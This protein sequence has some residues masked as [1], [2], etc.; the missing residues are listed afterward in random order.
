MTEEHKRKIGL[1]NKGKRLGYK[2]SEET[3]LKLSIA[4]KGITSWNKGIPMSDDLKEKISQST[5]KEKNHFWGKKH[6]QETKE[7]IS[8]SRKKLGLKSCNPVM[9]GE[10]NPSKRPE[11]KAKLAESKK[12]EKNPNW[13][14]G[15]STENALIRASSKY[16]YWR[17]SV[18]E[19]DNYTCLDCGA[20]NGNGVS[21]YLNA[22]HIKPFAY[23][24]KL[25]FELSNGKT[26]CVDCHRKT[27]TY[28]SRKLNMTIV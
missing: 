6:T 23:Y 20:K 19:R 27:E 22:D 21:V 15:V 18:F 7:K 1:A 25:R 28:G 4:H 3:K 24:P 8:N 9:Y 26:L 10:D 2:A 13:K 14:G 5:Q 12:G 16:R 17:E 11:V